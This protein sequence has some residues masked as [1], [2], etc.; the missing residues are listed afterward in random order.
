[1]SYN[2]KN[3]GVHGTNADTSQSGI[4]GRAEDP[5]EAACRGVNGHAV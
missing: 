3:S 1:L 4:R 5:S 2:R